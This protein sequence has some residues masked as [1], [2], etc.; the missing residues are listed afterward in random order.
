MLCLAKA[1]VVAPHKNLDLFAAAAMRTENV[2]IGIAH[3]A[4][5]GGFI[6]L[7]VA[8]RTARAQEQGNR[9]RNRKAAADGRVD[10]GVNSRGP[11][12]AGKAGHVKSAVSREMTFATACFEVIQANRCGFEE[13]LHWTAGDEVRLEHSV[14]AAAA[15][16]RAHVGH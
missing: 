9:A 10:R 14:V 11:T 15:I 12:A 2:E 6:L 4:V 16:S 1:A 3:E 13:I 5:E 8:N 7:A